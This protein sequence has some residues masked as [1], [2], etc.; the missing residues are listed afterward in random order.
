MGYVGTIDT[1]KHVKKDVDEIRKGSECGISFHGFNDVKEGDE[2][3]TFASFEVAR[4]L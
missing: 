2:V 3:V 4:E 1:L